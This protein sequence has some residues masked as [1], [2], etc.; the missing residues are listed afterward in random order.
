MDRSSRV[1]T[2]TRLCC[3]ILP[4][5]W[6]RKV[7][8]VVSTTRAPSIAATA[9][10]ICA[11]CSWLEASTV[12]SRSVCSSSIETRSMDPIIPPARPIAVAT[13]PSIPGRWAIST[14]IVREY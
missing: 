11:Q 10:R 8:S 6:S 12:M 2:G 3:S 14:R 5:T 13:L 9:S 4:P 1:F 7:R